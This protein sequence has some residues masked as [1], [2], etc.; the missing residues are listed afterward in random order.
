MFY[1]TDRFTGVLDPLVCYETEEE[2]LA[3]VA[4]LEEK[5]RKDGRYQEDLYVIIEEDP[6]EVDY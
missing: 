4:E 1:V 2:A 3:K 5:N 6:S